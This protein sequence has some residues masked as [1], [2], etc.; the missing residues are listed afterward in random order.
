ML[1][2][3]ILTLAA[4][5]LLSPLATATSTG[6]IT[7]SGTIS[8][9]VNATSHSINFSTGLP[10][11]AVGCLNAAGKVTLDD[12]AVFTAEAY[13]VSTSEGACSFHNA[14]Q[15]ANTDDVYGDSVYAFSC[16][17][18]ETVSTD[19]QFYT[20]GGLDYNF[21]GQGDAD[22]VS[23]LILL[24]CGSFFWGGGGGA[25]RV[26]GKGARAAAPRTETLAATW[27]LI[28]LPPCRA[29][30]DQKQAVGECETDRMA[31]L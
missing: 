16:W 17:D 10:S 30:R 3:S 8:V 31:V 23:I 24:T 6:T 13:H 7:G 25:A 11:Q 5:L 27:W 28:P 9:I 26:G 14:S 1:A 22:L 2:P 21:L 15:P 18:H 19:V 4:G 20:V 29:E 12:C